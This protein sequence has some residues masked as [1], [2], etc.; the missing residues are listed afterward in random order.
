M[1]LLVPKTLTIEK[2][3]ILFRGEL[4][5]TTSTGWF[6]FNPKDAESYGDVYRYEVL[7]D[8]QLVD[9]SNKKAI[10]DMR[11]CYDVFA[12]RTGANPSAFNSA[13]PRGDE[14]QVYR[15][16]EW[17]PDTMVVK[18]VEWARGING[19]CGEY[20]RHLRGFGNKESLP[21]PDLEK[22][23]HP[24]LFIFNPLEVLQKE[25]QVFLSMDPWK[26]REKLLK[27][28]ESQQRGQ[29]KRRPVYSSDDENED[30]QFFSKRKLFF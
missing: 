7:Q 2:G 21:H 28:Q 15:D 26:R 30:P 29:R 13:F 23:H 24:E 8:F 3:T 19:Q 16:T 17:E 18:M 11:G 27:R 20:F 6:A 25:N 22:P 10:D 4:E 14:K 1:A 9:L 5:A 12:Q